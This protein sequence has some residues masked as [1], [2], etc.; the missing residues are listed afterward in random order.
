VLSKNPLPDLKEHLRFKT[1]AQFGRTVFGLSGSQIG[2]VMNRATLDERYRQGALNWAYAN[3][4]DDPVVFELLGAQ[5]PFGEEA[6]RAQETSRKKTGWESSG[7]EPIERAAWSWGLSFRNSALLEEC[8]GQA[9][10][11]GLGCT[12]VRD[13]VILSA[14]GFGARKPGKDPCV[15]LFPEPK[16]FGLHAGTVLML[17]AS[18]KRHPQA[19]ELQQMF[20]E[21]LNRHQNICYIWQAEEPFRP[22]YYGYQTV[23]KFLQAGRTTIHPQRYAESNSVMIYQDAAAIFHGPIHTLFRGRQHPYG[24][25]ARQVILVAALQRLANGV[26]VRLL[27]DPEFRRCCVGTLDFEDSRKLGV[28]VFRVTVATDDYGTTI[29]LFEVLDTK[30]GEVIRAVPTAGGW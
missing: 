4:A 18:R 13:G 17:G 7:F 29:R 11:S 23:L 1:R 14:P 5:L 9:L 6:L 8:S 28:L 15:G 27:V 10:R 21:H 16:S 22:S 19:I 12:R 3:V 25:G 30:T 2:R 24:P 20:I 26:G